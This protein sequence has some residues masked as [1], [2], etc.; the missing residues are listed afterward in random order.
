MLRVLLQGRCYKIIFILARKD[1]SVR[2]IN[3]SYHSVECNIFLTFI[4]IQNYQD[5]LN[6]LNLCILFV[7]FLDIKNNLEFVIIN[8]DYIL[9]VCHIRKVIY[10]NE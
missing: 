8:Q 3:V 6:C 5:S 4:R 9:D 1:A 10:N 2:L 7:F